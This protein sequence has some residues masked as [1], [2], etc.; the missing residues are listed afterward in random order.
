MSQ[1]KNG[2]KGRASAASRADRY[3]L[4][5]RA[6]QDPEAEVDF[7]RRV[8]KEYRRGVPLR[9]REDFCGTALM[10][11][12]WVKQGSRFTAEGYDLDPEPLAWG[13]AHHIGKLGRA[14]QR[15]EL[16]EADVREASRI[17]PQVRCAQN[18]SYSVFQRRSE[19]LEYFTSVYRDL[20]N[21]GIFVMDLWGGSGATDPVRE[22][23]SI[24]RG[25][26][27]VWNQASFTPVT[28]AMT[29]HIE[30]KFKDGSQLKPAFSYDWRYWS[31]PELR[32]LLFEAGF[33]QLETY[34]EQ[35]TESGEGTGTFEKDDKGPVKVHYIAYLV[36]LK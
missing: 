24:G 5:Q 36:A 27:Y 35:Y 26:T 23:R 20:T 29:C 12:E 17:S 3:E 25:V 32:D 16:F 31:I 18:F 30:F 11:T 2:K 15:L 22:R 14:S 8:F 19:M 21:D 10:A 4:Y 6:V 1:K 33:S 34:F 9:L 7:I 13:R 28:G